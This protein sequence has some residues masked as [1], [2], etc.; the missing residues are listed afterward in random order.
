MKPV[1]GAIELMTFHHEV[2]IAFCRHLIKLRLNTMVIAPSHGLQKAINRVASASFQQLAESA[3]KE[4]TGFSLVNV[5]DANALTD[6]LA[7]CDA[8]FIGTFPPK[9]ASSPPQAHH[10]IR[11]ASRYQQA[12]DLINT[13][14]SQ[15]KRVYIVI[16]KPSSDANNLVS[17]LGAAACQQISVIYLSEDTASCSRKLFPNQFRAELIMPAI[18][19]G[20][21]SQPP[22]SHANCRMAIVGEISSK[23]RN[24]GQ[25]VRLNSIQQWLTKE[26]A[27]VEIIGRIKAE[28]WLD[29]I[30]LLCG[31][32]ASLLFLLR[33][34]ALT[35]L[36]LHGN[37]DLSKV[38]RRKIP[39]DSLADRLIQAAC[40]LD[41]KLDRYTAEGQTSGS[42]GLSLT[43]GKPLISIDQII[44]ASPAK[45]D[46]DSCSFQD[47][48]AR[49]TQRVIQRRT[50]LEAQF[51]NHLA[52]DL[53]MNSNRVDRSAKN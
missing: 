19:M 36:W 3:A 34:P 18:G 10:G 53:Q 1:V 47:L 33:Y 29:R 2:L 45:A 25:L 22:A 6:S 43:Y 7:H 4:G 23:R 44:D 15:D 46:A 8:I 49:E 14:L 42:E 9:P 16:H 38:G 20:E 11:G 5:N 12:I 41:L 30:L 35:S 48:L 17:S 26:R 24:Y 40:V 21:S 31:I 28:S 37:L 50:A 27:Q 52:S 51:H 32:P 39:E 13:A